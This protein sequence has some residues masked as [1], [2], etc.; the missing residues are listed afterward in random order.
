M[1]WSERNH[2]PR[3]HGQRGGRF[4]AAI[5]TTGITALLPPVTG[6]P[7]LSP[8]GTPATSGIA[9]HYAPTPQGNCSYP[10]PPPDGL[11]A[12]L[13]PSEY[14]NGSACGEYL[15]VAGPHG[16]SVQVEVTDQCPQCASS[17]IDL[18]EGAFSRLAPLSAGLI[19]VSYHTVTNPS[20]PAPVSVEVKPGSSASWLALLPMSTGNP[21]SSV[22]VQN[23]SGGWDSLT[24][25]GYG[26]WIAQQ[27]EGPGPFTVRL[28]DTAGHTVTLNGIT[29]SP[30]GTQNTGTWMYGNATAPGLPGL[31]P[32]G[33]MRPDQ[34]RL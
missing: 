13:S 20:L 30:G 22:Q 31:N 9:T 17:H 24:Q 10:S 11:Y 12:A 14:A 25:S 5:A 6:L 2:T 16:G 28:T 4:A 18:S 8:P 26:Y 34:G 23:S 15:D 27:G 32:G 1:R 19:N 7:G 29:L 33:P 3:K 21:L